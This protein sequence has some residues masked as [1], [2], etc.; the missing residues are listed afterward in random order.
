MI[1]SRVRILLDGALAGGCGAAVIAIWFLLLD[2]VRGQPLQTPEL[3][4]ASLVPWFH[5]VPASGAV[6]WTLI[7]GYSLFHFMAF[8][9]IGMAGALMMEA[10][11]R[12]PA[13]FP[14][15]FI[16]LI[17]FEMFFIAL[18]MLL[19]PAAAAVMPWWKVMIG[20]ALATAAMLAVFLWR[21]PILFDNLLGPWIGV[22]TEG[23]AAGIIGAVVLA[24]WF[25]IC[26]F[27]AGQV[28]RTPSLLGSVMLG[29]ASQAGI[30][31]PMVIG[32]SALHFI[33]FIAFGIA[34][35]IF[36]YG[37]EREPLL[38][39]GVLM[40]FLWFEVSFLGAITVMNSAA[41]E[42]LGWWRIIAGNLITLAAMIGYFEYGHAQIIPRIAQRWNEI[43]T[44]GY[45][46]G[47]TINPP[48]PM[49]G[50]PR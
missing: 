20:N 41:L 30:S 7:A 10:A 49:S 4:G 38:A 40:I 24:L 33:A 16:F 34:A 45:V 47:R 5:T 46:R 48:R 35:S 26:D 39:L 6:P 23:I 2:L 31:M 27:A 15:L 36:V 18:V 32:Y 25:L 22:M 50:T 19:G 12:D 42:Q 9:I 17:A 29:G 44:E 8:A 14:S 43:S 11:E 1:H 13:L 21:Q 37:S 28:F 3:L